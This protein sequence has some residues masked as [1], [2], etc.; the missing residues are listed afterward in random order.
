MPKGDDLSS[1]WIGIFDVKKPERKRLDAAQGATGAACSI[2][3]PED[4]LFE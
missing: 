1:S 2:Q 3:Y 4:A